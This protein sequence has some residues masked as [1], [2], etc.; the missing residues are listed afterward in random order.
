[1]R[2][3]KL[4]LGGRGMIAAIVMMMAVTALLPGCGQTAPEKQVDTYEELVDA[5]S[6]P[7]DFDIILPDTESLGAIDLEHSLFMIN[8]YNQ[9]RRVHTGYSISMNIR[10]LPHLRGGSVFCK[11]PGYLTFA[12]SVPQDEE[13]LDPNTEYAG[14]PI[15]F[16]IGEVSPDM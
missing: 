10:E 9:D 13:P 12:G 3:K 11:K 16:Y 7:E 5:L 8:L 4:I 2:N 14:V 15:Q 6:G 1:M